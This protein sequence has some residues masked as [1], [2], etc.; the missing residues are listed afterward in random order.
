MTDRFH[1]FAYGSNMSL[2]RLQQRTPSARRLHAPVRLPGYELRFHKIGRDGSG[3]CDIIASVAPATVVYGVLF[4]ILSREKPHLDAA[5]SLGTGYAELE[6]TIEL[7]AGA[8][9]SAV[10]YQALQTDPQLRPF[11]WYRH[12]VLSGAREAG[13]PRHYIAELTRVVTTEDPDAARARREMSIYAD[14]P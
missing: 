8:R 4:S 6:V 13:L 2:A 14:L 9:V 7:Q 3:K 10:T 5:E 11:D 12:H 1:Y